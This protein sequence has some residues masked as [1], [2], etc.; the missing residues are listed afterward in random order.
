MSKEVVFGKS[1]MERMMIGFDLAAASVIGTLGPKGRN[2]FIDDPAQPK[3]TNDGATIATHIVL[4]NNLEN[5]GAKILKNTCGQT[6]DNAGDGTTTTAVLVHSIVHECLA[7][8]ENPMVIRESLIKAG[9]KIVPLIK[10]SSKPI[11][12]KD[13]KKVALISAEDENLAQNISEIINKIGSEAVIT[14]EDSLDFNTT[15][16]I[17]NGYEA[18]VGFMSKAFVTDTKRARCV[19][20]DVPVFVTEKKIATLGDISPLFEKFKEKGITS[21]VIV[22]DDIENSMLGVFVASKMAGTFNA[23]VIRAT[24]D[25]LKDIEAAVGATRVSDETGVTFQMV[26]ETHLGHVKKVISDTNKTVFMP[27]DP[28]KAALYANILQR[29]ANDE[30]NMYIKQ[31][32]DRR[33]AQLRGGVAILRIGGQ[34]FEREYLKDKA[35]DAIK[36]SK[37]ALE[38]GVVEGGGLALWRIAKDMKPQTI[39]EQILKTAL[40]SPIRKILENASKDYTEVIMKL[41][42]RLGYDAKND[43]FVDMFEYG[44]IDP[45]KVVRNALENSIANA[46]QFITMFCAVT[47]KNEEKK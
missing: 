34:D 33:I 1:A 42:D 21:C 6:N 29:F 36:A 46:A 25:L 45:T 16:E 30:P 9:K 13:V 39:G 35:D 12:K 17:V 41:N 47:E 7:R 22:C 18:N 8:P 11:T 2:V 24:G 10:K 19:M 44:I 40:T 28:A 23:V 4:E 14:V 32:L 3:F 38:E 37:A 15:Y 31:R 26:D 5:A 43:V 20:T 27:T